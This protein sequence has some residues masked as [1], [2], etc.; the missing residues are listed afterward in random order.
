[1]SVSRRDDGKL[2]NLVCGRRTIRDPDRLL[3]IDRQAWVGMVNRSSRKA[4]LRFPRRS[5]CG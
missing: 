3:V 1:M 4:A 2:N 5:L